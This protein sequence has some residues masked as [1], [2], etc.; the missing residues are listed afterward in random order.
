ME[1]DKML[2]L[3]EV[4][5]FGGCHTRLGLKELGKVSMVIKPKVEHNLL[6]CHFRSLQ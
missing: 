2:L 5:K 4:F 1:A 3:A 6:H